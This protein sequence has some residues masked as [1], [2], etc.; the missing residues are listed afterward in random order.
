MVDRTPEIATL[1]RQKPVAEGPIQGIGQHN[2]TKA[3]LD[4]L[5]DR[6]EALRRDQ[7]A[8]RERMAALLPDPPKDWVS[9]MTTG[10]AALSG[11]TMRRCPQ[12]APLPSG[13]IR[14]S[15]RGVNQPR[16][17]GG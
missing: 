4:V 17:P 8:L 6:M 1:L 5:R 10:H 14:G 3:A 13:E 16:D 11:E 7:N 15:R 12:V 2:A 9:I